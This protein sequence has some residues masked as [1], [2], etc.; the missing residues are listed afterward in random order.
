MDEI[1]RNDTE[2]LNAALDQPADET[3]TYYADQQHQVK[4]ALRE[5]G[6]KTHRALHMKR[7][8]MW[9][10]IWFSITAAHMMDGAKYRCAAC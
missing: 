2:K 7:D 8:A 6:A 4:A 1:D 3:V 9:S 10:K 5:R